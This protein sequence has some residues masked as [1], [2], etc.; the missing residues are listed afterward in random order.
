MHQRKPLLTTTYRPAIQVTGC[1]SCGTFQRVPKIA[2]SAKIICVTCR[3]MLERSHWR[4]RT[5]TLALTLAAFTLL[6]PA[7]IY[8][9]L[10]TSILGASRQSHLISSATAM[11]GNG[12]PLLALVIGLFVVV[13]PFVRLGLL[14]MV[15]GSLHYRQRPPWLGPAFRYAC[16]LETWAMPDVFLLGLLVAYAR[17]KAS[18]SLEVGAGAY[19]FIAVGILTLFIRATL[20]KT[21]IWRQIMAEKATPANASLITCPACELVLEQ[22]AEGHACPRCA[23]TLHARKPDATARALA[24]TV[25]GAALYLPANI[26]PIATLPVGFSSFSYNILGGAIELVQSQLYPYAA[27]V[28]VASFAIPLMKLVGI[29]WCIASV[30]LRSNKALRAKTRVYRIIEEIGRWSMVDPFVIACFVPVSE[31]TSLVYG[32]AQPAAQAFT[33]VVILTIFAARCFDPRLMWDRA[34][35]NP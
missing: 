6:L 3:E 20:D 9:V 11:A 34:R 27:L 5:V 15:L 24:L 31:Y 12:F 4:N 10:T 22:H 16:D 14:V 21:L 28:I 26:Y 29:V 35:K 23:A 18:I 19:S 32:R 25:A 2:D 17:L 1:P 8:P 7:N 30:E 33:A 13:F